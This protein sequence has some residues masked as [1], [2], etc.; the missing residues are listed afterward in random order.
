M[1][2]LQNIKIFSSL[3]HQQDLVTLAAEG[4]PL[5]E[6]SLP[7]SRLAEN[8]LAARAHNHSLGVAEHSGSAITNIE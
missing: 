4:A 8:S 7:T 1:E 2:R 3:K 6:P 5:G